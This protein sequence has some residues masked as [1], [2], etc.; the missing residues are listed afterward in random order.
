M[1]SKLLSEQPRQKRPDIQTRRGFIDTLD[2]ELFQL[3]QSILI[4]PSLENIE[5]TLWHRLQAYSVS[6]HITQETQ[7]QLLSVFVFL[8]KI[9]CYY[10]W[11]DR[12]AVIEGFKNIDDLIQ[13]KQLQEKDLHC[14]IKKFKW[15]K[16]FSKELSAQLLPGAFSS[17]SNGLCR[18]FTVF[19]ELRNRSL[20][21]K[22]IGNT[23]HFDGKLN[24]QFL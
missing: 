3:T 5:N 4:C 16:E 18:Q 9:N 22:L 10:F 19:P 12:S 7:K 23:K 6:K 8:L 21:D 1:Q 14:L 24:V 15:D 2:L 11:Q 13:Q 20:I 17:S